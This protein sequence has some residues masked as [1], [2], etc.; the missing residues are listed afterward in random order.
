VHT[1]YNGLTQVPAIGQ[2]V[3]KLT[4]PDTL[5]HFRWWIFS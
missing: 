5:M 1:C 4:L 2:G 3:H